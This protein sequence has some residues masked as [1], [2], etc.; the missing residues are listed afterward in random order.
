MS[1]WIWLALLAVVL[2]GGAFGWWGRLGQFIT[3]FVVVFV[4]QFM[5]RVFRQ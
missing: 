1:T 3:G 2:W 4:W 5:K